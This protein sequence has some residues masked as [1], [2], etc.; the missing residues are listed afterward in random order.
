[1]K[2]LGN[3][4]ET[5]SALS[6]KEEISTVAKMLSNHFKFEYDGRDANGHDDEYMKCIWLPRIASVSTPEPEGIFNISYNAKT[7]LF[8]IE[9]GC[10][11]LISGHYYDNVKD[12]IIE[13][14]KE[15]NERSKKSLGLSEADG[16]DV[17]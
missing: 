1:M 10:K 14:L 17:L 15:N 4:D 16:Q 3:V 12:H 9:Y 2:F 11:W 7:F 5:T 6:C 8:A 13:R